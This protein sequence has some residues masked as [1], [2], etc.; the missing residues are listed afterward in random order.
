MESLEPKKLL[1]I[2]SS[3]GGGLLQTAHAKQQ[4]ALAKDP[5][6]VIV[7]KDLLKD[8]V[9]FGRL[10]VNV[11]NSAQKGGKVS[12]QEVVCVKGQPVWD[13]FLFPLLFVKA[14]WTIFK[15]DVDHVIDTQPL[16]TAAIV[17][18]LRVFNWRKKKQ[19]RVEKVL[20]DLPTKK[21]TH[22][23]TP[24]KNLSQ[25][26]KK[27]L[28]LVSIAPLLE[29]GETAEAFWQNMC[30]LSDRDIHYEEAYV[31]EAFKQ[32]RGKP[33]TQEN[34]E[35]RI[36]F[37][38]E[39]ELSL[40]RN[41]SRIEGQEV[42]FQIAPSDRV[43]TILLGSQ[44]AKEATLN[45]VKKAIATG[46]P[47]TYLFVF[48]GD[49][50]VGKESL[51]RSVSQLAASSPFPVIPFSFQSEKV[52][53]PLFHRSDITCTRSGGQ[54]AMELMSVSTGE[55]WIHSEAKKGEDLLAGIPGWESASAVYLQRLYG[56]KIVTPDTFSLHQKDSGQVRASSTQR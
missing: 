2:T 30:G 48:C 19:I 20:V 15:E 25:N 3:G 33:R 37:K 1:I 8:W 10:F 39:E 13:F 54:T 6:L 56:A 5:H 21:A 22:F 12:I 50:K 47:N 35:L 52:I 45:Y 11:W 49:H 4:E 23:F 44:P 7:K 43:I 31:R 36:R 26:S 9:P 40:I 42:V 55:I 29:E 34:V 14:L 18:A 38:T 53:A 32:Y 27:A 46:Q 17:K 16:G 51:F 41:Y 28:K 24:I